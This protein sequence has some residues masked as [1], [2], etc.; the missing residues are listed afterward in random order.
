[1]QGPGNKTWRVPFG[2]GATSPEDIFGNTGG[3]R[4]S[5][6]NELLD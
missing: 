4:L 5:C 3:F 2:A 6:V 1:M